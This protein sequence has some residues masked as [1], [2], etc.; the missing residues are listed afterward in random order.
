MPR[1]HR[2]KKA[3]KEWYCDRCGATVER[4]APYVWWEF[5]FG[6]KRVRCGAEACRPKASELTQSAIKG[7]A[8]AI[9]EDYDPASCESFEALAEM[10]DD[11]AQAIQDIVDELQEKIDNIESGMGNWMPIC[12]E[13]EERRG[14]YESWHDEVE[15]VD[16][17]EPDEEPGDE[18][19][20]RFEGED[21]DSFDER[22]GD[23][24]RAK[25]AWDEALD[26]ART[27]LADA[28]GACPE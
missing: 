13:L 10:R 4:G 21:D 17:D 18:A 19:P 9:Q 5:R 14:E 6:G 3:A 2:V 1:V 23:W 7:A 8:Y 15:G 16:A 11:V 20:E 24:K 27:A 28:I 25:E 22:V 26:E 12:D